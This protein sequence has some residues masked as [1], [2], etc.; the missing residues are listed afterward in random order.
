VSAVRSERGCAVWNA[1]Q[2]VA[3]TKQPLLHAVHHLCDAVNDCRRPQLNW[4]AALAAVDAEFRA[5]QKSSDGRAASAALT[6]SAPSPRSNHAP[7]H[8]TG[9]DL[10]FIKLLSAAFHAQRTASAKAGCLVHPRSC[11]ASL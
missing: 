8:N 1:F 4:S 5:P 11:A 10:C 6:A 3:G 2:G 9:L 7:L